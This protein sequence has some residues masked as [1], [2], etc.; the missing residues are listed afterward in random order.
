[1][2][3]IIQTILQMI[4]I[5][6]PLRKEY[7]IFQCHNPK[8]YCDN[9]KY[10]FEYL[11]K[12]GFKNCYW[13]TSSEKIS[14]YLKKKNY[15]YI[16]KDQNLIKFFFV[17][18]KTKI[19]IDTGT[20]Y[21]DPLELI[22]NDKE[23]IKITLYHGYGPK[24]LPYPKKNYKIRIQDINNHQSFDYINFTSK[25]IEKKYIDNFKLQKRNCLNFGFPRVDYLKSNFKDKTFN[26]LTSK[27][28]KNPKIILYTPTWR[29][30][31][32]EFPLNYMP[33]MNYSKFE[34]FLKDKNL[35]FFF[36]Q[37]PVQDFKNK[38]K[39]YSRIIYIDHLKYPFYDPTS[40]MKSVKILFNDYSAT[41]TEFSLLKKPQLFYFP[42]Y[43]KYNEYNGFLENYKKNLI[44]FETK[45]YNSLTTYITKCLQNKSFYLKKFNNQILRYQ[46]KYYDKLNNNSCKLF[47]KLIK[48]I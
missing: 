11:N 38:P 15:R 34:K 20:K 46:L 12:K 3:K 8:L 44:G 5:I 35:Y 37:H 18:F 16:N 4:K 13:H 33:G 22:S 7:I 48:K 9:S 29:P 6:F 39:N 10:L 14:N 41:S 24:A 23:V 17:T 36:S 25:F 45:D 31:D 21:F 30:Y 27:K 43:K 28:D 40:F 32:I 19:V 47:E 2:K 1:M 26:Y 42:D